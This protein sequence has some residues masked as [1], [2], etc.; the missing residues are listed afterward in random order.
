MDNL[1]KILK[2]YNF[3][4]Y[5]NNYFRILNDKVFQF[6][7]STDY[8]GLIAITFESIPLECDKL[9]FEELNQIDKFSG[10]FILSEI[11]GIKSECSNKQEAKSLITEEMLDKLNRLIDVETHIKYYNQGFFVANNIKSEA[12]LGYY[13]FINDYYS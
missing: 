2:K 11:I 7:G 5:K 1:N 6:I 9:S 13:L 12:P 10:G 4:K 8:N 3:I